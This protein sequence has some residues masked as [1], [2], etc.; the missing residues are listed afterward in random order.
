MSSQADTATAM[1][2]CIDEQ[3]SAPCRDSRRAQPG[4]RPDRGPAARALRPLL[5]DRRQ[6]RSPAGPAGCAAQGSLLCPAAQGSRLQQPMR[7]ASAN[8]IWPTTCRSRRTSSWSNGSLPQ[9]LRFVLSHT[10]ANTDLAQRFRSIIA[11]PAERRRARPGTDRD[12]LPARCRYRASDALFRSGGERHPRP[13]RTLGRRR[14]AA[15]QSAGKDISLFARIALLA[16]VVDVFHASTGRARPALADRKHRAGGL[17]RS[18]TLSRPSDRCALFDDFWET[19]ARDDLE[20][21]VLEMEPGQ[22]GHPGRRRLSRRHSRRP[23]PV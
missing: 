19:L 7:R 1:T 15:R 9:V 12:P 8:S 13:R 10:G 17:V 4:A 20:A 16:Q 18:C 23:S 5:L 2:S 14:Q 6:H 21:I 3:G 11:H 22:A